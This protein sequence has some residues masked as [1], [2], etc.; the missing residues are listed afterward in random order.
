MKEQWISKWSWFSRSFQTPSQNLKPETIT[1]WYQS[2]PSW[3][4]SKYFNVNSK[5]LWKKHKEG[6]IAAKKRQQ[7]LLDQLEP[8]RRYWNICQPCD[9]KNEIKATMVASMPKDEDGLSYVP[10]NSKLDFHWYNSELDLLEW[11]SRCEIFCR[12]QRTPEKDKERVSS[13][14]LY[15]CSS[16]GN[17]IGLSYSWRNLWTNAI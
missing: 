3:E 9:R 12:H 6:M 17:E 16:N 2:Q 15:H 8:W 13:F 11:L 14:H 4:N 7:G 10:Q 5:P 1:N